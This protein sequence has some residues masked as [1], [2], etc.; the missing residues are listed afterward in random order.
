M[1]E[2][3]FPHADRVFSAFEIP[4]TQLTI[5]LAEKPC[6]ATLTERADRDH[7]LS[8]AFTRRSLYECHSDFQRHERSS[9]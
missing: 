7:L 6:G 5:Q 8:E 3:R 9:N 1:T 4:G 2:T